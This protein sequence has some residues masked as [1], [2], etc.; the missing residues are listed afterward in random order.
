M[1]TY[2]QDGKVGEWAEEKLECL[3][4]YLEAYTT[5]MRKQDWATS[6]YFDAFAGGGISELRSNEKIDP[7]DVFLHPFKLDPVEKKYIEGSPKRA[8]SIK[9]PFSKYFFV[10]KNSNRVKQLKSLSAEFSQN[11]QIEIIQ[12]DAL[13]AIK[14]FLHDPRNNWVKCRAVMFLDPFG[15][16]VPWKIIEEIARTGAIEILINFPVGMA[17]QRLLPNSGNISKA[18]K[19]KL[20]AYF[21]T[22]GWRQ[23]VYEARPNLFGEIDEKKVE[24]SSKK[25]ATW[26]QSRLKGIFGH[27][28]KPRLIKNPH[29]TH[30]YYLIFAGPNATGARIAGEVL[31][32]SKISF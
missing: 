31:N 7:E 28:P 12:G 21:G 17:I 6:F 19:A 18:T 22:N 14:E 8:L 24:E 20:D 27:S 11:R 32:Q 5:I 16:Q 9:H 25:L 15:M 1:S 30:L 4:K 29:G 2:K 10:E 3:A 23:I 13:E 26:Y